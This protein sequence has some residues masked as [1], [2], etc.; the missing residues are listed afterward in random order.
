EPG[1]TRVITMQPIAPDAGVPDAAEPPKLVC[2]S[3]TT[4]TLAPAPEMTWFCARDTG[5]RHGPFVTQFPDG[6][7]EIS[8]TYKDGK[9]DGQWTRRYPGGGVAEDGAY[10]NG[11]KDGAW[12]QLAP[13]GSLLGDYTMKAGTGTEK[14]WY[15]DGPL[16]SER[17]FKAGVPHGVLKIYDH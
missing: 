1:E 17:G 16:Y 6:A 3:G 14:R 13:S 4:A 11:M 9:L 5:V 8:G 7:I 15:D 12:K 10:A 2:D